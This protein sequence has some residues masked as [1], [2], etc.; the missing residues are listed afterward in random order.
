MLS[1][2]SAYTQLSTS[3]RGVIRST[4]DV[5]NHP[6]WNPTLHKLADIEEDEAGKLRAFRERFGRGWDSRVE[7]ADVSVSKGEGGE[8]AEAGAGEVGAEGEQGRKREENLMDLISGGYEDLVMGKNKGLKVKKG[9]AA[10]A[11]A[12]AAGA[13]AAA[14]GG[15]AEPAAAGAGADKKKKK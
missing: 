10:A 5:R 2:G 14:A 11:A 1:D 9:A 4:K 3:P 13:V 12:A 6:L 15:K 8:G 7:E